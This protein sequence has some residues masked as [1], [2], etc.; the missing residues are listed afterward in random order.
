MLFQTFNVVTCWKIGQSNKF[1]D[2]IW[3][4]KLNCAIIFSMIIYQFKFENTWNLQLYSLHCL[5]K[6]V[7]T[8][9]KQQAWS[10]IMKT[11]SD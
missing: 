5:E 2:L 1:E 6:I 4:E 9:I 7:S 8:L 3:H 11:Y 10:E